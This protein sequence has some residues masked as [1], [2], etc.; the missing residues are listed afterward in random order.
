MPYKHGK[1]Y[2]VYV[3]LRDGRRRCSTG[4]SELRVAKDIENTLR[5]L[6]S[7]RAFDL[8]E[9]AAFEKAGLSIGVLYDAFKHHG[10]TGLEQLRAQLSDVKLGDYIAAWVKWA[11]QKASFDTV[12]KYEKQV[13]WFVPETKTLLR[14]EF[15]RRY[16][17]ERLSELDGSSS[18][19]QR[20]HRALSNFAKYLVE[21]E[22][23]QDNPLRHVQCPRAN[24]PREVFLDLQT[25]MQL[26]NALAE[27]YKSAVAI[28]EGGG[29]EFSAML[30]TR[31]RDIQS[32]ESR[33][34][35]ANGSK[36]EWRS[37]SVVIDEWAWPAIVA[38]TKD[39]LPNALLFPITEDQDTSPKAARR[40]NGM[41]RRAIQHAKKAAGVPLEYTIHDARHSFAVRHM[42]AGDPPDVIAA[43]LGHKDATL[44]IRIYGKYRPNDDDRRR[45]SAFGNSGK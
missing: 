32:K 41:L 45:L 13:R 25:S 11:R 7:R 22:V 15:T 19:K 21:Q 17:S 18:T 34:V 26:V 8:L 37:R 31:C 2:W 35:F 16:I 23:L 38:A 10:D 36:N 44:V 30:R 28:M 14:S 20:Y 3:P 33:T 40:A 29:V 1:L 6:K 42:R 4:T 43:N 39:K 5:T 12:S 9:A 24:R 27:P